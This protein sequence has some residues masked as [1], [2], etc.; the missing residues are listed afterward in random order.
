MVLF[1]WPLKVTKHCKN[2]GFSRH[3]GKPKMTLL[4][5]K[6]P[7]WERGLEKGALLSVIPKSCALL[8]THFY[9]IS[10]KLQKP[11]KVISCNFRFFC[12]PQTSVFKIH[13][14]SYFV[15]F[16]VFLLSSL[17]KFPFCFL[18]INPFSKT[19]L[20]LVSF[21]IS[22]LFLMIACLFA[23]NFP[24]IPF[25]NPNCFHFWLF[26]FFCCFR[27]L[28]SWCMFLPFCFYVGFVFGNLFLGFCVVSVLLSVCEKNV[29]SLQF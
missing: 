18:S 5:A 16:L 22:C 7:F 19:L 26:F 20:C 28:F 9:S 29:V 17:S 27:F 13:F 12:S 6:V 3:K 14:S 1:W 24:N 10:N 11:Q 25:L 23:T 4:V 8:K 2:R 21:I 15:F